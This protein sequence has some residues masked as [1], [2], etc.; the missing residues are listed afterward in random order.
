MKYVFSCSGPACIGG[1]L[2]I[3]TANNEPPTCEYCHRQ[4]SL[5]RR[6][7]EI[8]RKAYGPCVDRL[9]PD[10]LRDLVASIA[11]IAYT[12]G[13]NDTKARD[14]IRTALRSYKIL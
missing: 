13:F 9:S 10:T 14:M 11:A 6:V 3:Q 1:A 4:L 12:P 8:D 2:Q 5:V 7:Y